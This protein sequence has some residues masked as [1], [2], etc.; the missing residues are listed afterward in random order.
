MKKLLLL[1]IPFLFTG[2]LVLS[3]GDNVFHSPKKVDKKDK[4]ADC[5]RY[6]ATTAT[7]TSRGYI[8]GEE[9]KAKNDTTP[10]KAKKTKKTK[11]P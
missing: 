4:K 5:C 6:S 7:V 2:C 8:F 1:T 9:V 10:K 3:F 11:G